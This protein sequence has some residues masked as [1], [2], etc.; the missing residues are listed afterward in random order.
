MQTMNEHWN[1]FFKTG[2]LVQYVQSTGH[3]CQSRRLSFWWRWWACHLDPAHWSCSCMSA[4]CWYTSAVS[5]RGMKVW[6]DGWIQTSL[7]G[8]S[9]RRSAM[10]II[11]LYGTLPSLIR[12]SGGSAWSGCVTGQVSMAGW[13]WDRQDPWESWPV[14]SFPPWI[15]ISSM[16]SGEPSVGA[17]ARKHATERS[18]ELSRTVCRGYRWAGEVLGTHVSTE[19]STDQLAERAEQLN[20]NAYSGW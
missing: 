18:W 10:P 20:M 16:N 14:C 15:Q 2:W 19:P 8:C 17:R 6:P 5:A 4:S 12:C 1:R 11:R 7:R 13:S 9:P 3:S